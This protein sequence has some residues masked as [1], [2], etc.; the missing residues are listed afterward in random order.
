MPTIFK[1]R[2]RGLI[3]DCEGATAIEYGLILAFLGIAIMTA[4]QGL[5]N[6]VSTPFTRAGD[7]LT[8]GNAA[9]A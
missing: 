5:G 8:V 4:L 9:A 3:A 2:Q 6:E 1:P 7:A